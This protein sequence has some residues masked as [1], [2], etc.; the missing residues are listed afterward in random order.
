MRTRFLRIMLCG[1]LA[2]SLASRVGAEPG[3]APVPLTPELLRAVMPKVPDDQATRFAEL[4]NTTLKEFDINSP[5]RQAAFLAQLAHE[6]GQLR[7]MEEIASGEAYE[8]RKDLGNTQPGDG[9][10]YKGRGPIQLTGRANY[11]M[12][13]QA[14]GLDLEGK[15]EQA[16][17]PEVG[18]RVAGWFWK[19]HG[20]NELADKRDFRA[21]TRRINGG[22]NGLE[23]RQKYY[24]NALKALGANR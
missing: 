19:S 1:L 7:H 11:R 10:R 8:G 22:L 2:L 13:G 5:R 6:S 23:S 16:A 4:L 14:L 20:L 21:I 24:D 15:P 9:K 17:Q 3:T 18:F 12:A